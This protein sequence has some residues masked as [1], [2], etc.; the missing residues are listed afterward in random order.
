M[1]FNYFILF[2]NVLL[3]N[4]LFHFR[5]CSAYHPNMIAI[6]CLFHSFQVDVYFFLLFSSY[7]VIAFH[8][9]THAYSVHTWYCLLRC[10]FFYTLNS[11]ST[12]FITF[13]V[14][15]HFGPKTNGFNYE[16]TS[17]FIFKLTNDLFIGFIEV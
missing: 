9:I 3:H 13:Y 14:T 17:C 8:S 10:S 16:K 1:S 11:F 6:P 2:Y 4:L 5:G 7:D 15:V 12:D